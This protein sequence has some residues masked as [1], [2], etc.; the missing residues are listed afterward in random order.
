MGQA[1]ACRTLCVLSVWGR[2]G[3][4]IGHNAVFFF[5]AHKHCNNIFSR[6]SGQSPKILRAKPFGLERT[7]SQTVGEFRRRL[8]GTYSS[9][10][11]DLPYMG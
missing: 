3:G 6:Q 11:L 7:D 8:K 9:E 4:G 1:A 5:P 10:V 2:V